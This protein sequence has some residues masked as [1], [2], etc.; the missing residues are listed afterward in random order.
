MGQDARAAFIDRAERYFHGDPRCPAPAGPARDVRRR[1]FRGRNGRGL[2]YADHRRQ[3]HPTGQPDDR[4][5]R[6]V[7][8]VT[9]T[10]GRRGRH[11][12]IVMPEGKVLPVRL[13]LDGM[14][15][16]WSPGLLEIGW[17]RL[18]LGR[19]A[20]PR[21][22]VRYWMG[23]WTTARPPS[24]GRS[25]KETSRPALACRS[26]TV[27]RRQMVQ[28]SP[29]TFVMAQRIMPRQDRISDMFPGD[30]FAC[31]TQSRHVFGDDA[32]IPRAR[33]RSPSAMLSG[34]TLGCQCRCQVAKQGR[35]DQPVQRH[36][37]LATPVRVLI[38]GRGHIDRRKLCRHVLQPHREQT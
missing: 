38:D 31:R 17:L 12:C 19:P 2:P 27:K 10:S 6:V 26:A 37:Q 25:T 18:T 3:A 1:L 8:Q 36:G 28:P 11:R 16:P 21:C 34:R 23:R 5:Q 13:T 30:P 24:S 14:R 32:S 9:V 4:P 33:N 35:L 22:S 7:C 29:R 15:L 20:A